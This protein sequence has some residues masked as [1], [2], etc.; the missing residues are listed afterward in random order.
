MKLRGNGKRRAG[1]D[2]QVL[3]RRLADAA[4]DIA[5][6]RARLRT[7]TAR[8]R[9]LA[10]QAEIADGQRVL[11]EQLIQR[12]V[13]QLMERDERIAELE[14]LVKAA[15]DDTVEVPVPAAAQL[16]AA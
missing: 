9:A 12:Q 1:A 14:R 8:C 16:A 10:A 4:D 3:R 2:N 6:H 11:A 13:I 15:S 7:V 5:W